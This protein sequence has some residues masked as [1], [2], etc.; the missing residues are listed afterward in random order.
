MHRLPFDRPGIWCKTN[1][2][3]HSTVSDGDLDPAA[4][5]AAYA[6][7]GYDA[8]SL[9]DHFLEKYGYPITDTR[10]LRTA[11]MTTLIGAELHGPALSHGELWHIVAVGLPLDFARP[12]AD[13]TGPQIAARA[14]AAGAFV[15]IAHPAWYRLSLA[16]ALLVAPHADAVEVFNSTARAHN[17][18]GDGWYLA[19]GLAIATGRPL[20][21]YAADDTHF[22]ATRPDAFRSWTMVRAAERSPE[23]ILAGLKAGAFYASQ[24]PQ[25]HRI[26][27]DGDVIHVET[28]PVEEA[29]ITGIGSASAYARLRA[30]TRFTLPVAKF[31]GSWA[32]ITV[33]D[34]A[35]HRAWSNPFAVEA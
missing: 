18:S 28:S 7:Q 22:R 11:G 29:Y 17:D 12:A 35:G 31:A 26:E 13:E 24:G 15:G 6:A 4:V 27:R 9:T 20:M 21:A 1:L 33:V 5:V 32:R 19:D 10:S 16:D 23:A 25:I 2:H 34:A 30:M 14:A 8:I 3:T